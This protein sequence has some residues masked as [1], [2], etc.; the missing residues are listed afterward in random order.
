MSHALE[1][2]SPKGEGLMFIGKCT[3]C[4]EEGLKPEAVLQP[5]PMDK[6]ISDEQAL[7]GLFP[8]F[9]EDDE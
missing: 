5:C 9:R 8:E 7:M 1:R 3:K 6:Q 4:G 2:T